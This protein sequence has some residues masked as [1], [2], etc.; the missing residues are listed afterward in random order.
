MDLDAR[1]S[2]VQLRQQPGQGQVIPDPETMSH[3]VQPTRVQPRVT[4]QDLEQA[5]GSRILE[6]N[7]LDVLTYQCSPSSQ[8]AAVPME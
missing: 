7:G 6:V 4:D 5:A 2:P 3:P 8:P 1:E